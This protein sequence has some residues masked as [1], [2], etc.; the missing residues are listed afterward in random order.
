MRMSSSETVVY[1]LDNEIYLF[2]F[3]PGNRECVGNGDNGQGH[4]HEKTHCT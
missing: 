4:K 3:L 2:T 1:K